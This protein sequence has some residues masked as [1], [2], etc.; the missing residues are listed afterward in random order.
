[1]QYAVKRKDEMQDQVVIEK[2]KAVTAWCEHASKHEIE[3][4]GKDWVYL[5]IP[6]ND[7]SE[8]MTV[9]GLKNLYQYKSQTS[10]RTF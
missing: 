10:T 1:M 4:G 2:A 8:N 3:H 9:D 6:H 5:L 7:V